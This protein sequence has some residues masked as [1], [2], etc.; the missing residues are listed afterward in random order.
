MWLWVFAQRSRS[1][2]GEIFSL[3]DPGNRLAFYFLKAY[4][5]IKPLNFFFF[6]NF[7]GCKSRCQLTGSVSVCGLR[8]GSIPRPQTG[9]WQES[10]SSGAVKSQSIDLLGAHR[11]A[12]PHLVLVICDTG[13]VLTLRQQVPELSRHHASPLA[14]SGL[15][16]GRPLPG[17]AVAVLFLFCLPS[18]PTLSC[19]RLFLSCFNILKRKQWHFLR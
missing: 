8:M 5:P 2:R 4:V 18:L 17:S 10:T 9:I 1:F 14:E 6:F 12:W 7:P 13:F 3:Y 19:W 16:R 15:L 11:W